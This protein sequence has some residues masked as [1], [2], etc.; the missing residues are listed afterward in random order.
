[1]PTLTLKLS[2]SAL[3]CVT[4]DDP[5][6]PYVV[7]SPGLFGEMRLHLLGF[8]RDAAPAVDLTPAEAMADPSAALGLLPVMAGD[9]AP[10]VTWNCDV[11]AAS[12]ADPVT[13]DPGVLPPRVLHIGV[14]RDRLVRLMDL[15]APAVQW[16]IDGD[17][18]NTWGEEPGEDRNDDDTL[19][20]S[21]RDA[22]SDADAVRLFARLHNTGMLTKIADGL[23][24]EA[25][26][27]L[28]DPHTH[29]EDTARID[30]TGTVT[31]REVRRRVCAD[32]GYRFM[33]LGACPNVKTSCL[34]CCGEDHGLSATASPALLGAADALSLAIFA[35]NTLL[36]PDASSSTDFEEFEARAADALDVLAALRSQVAEEADAPAPVAA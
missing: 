3:I 24:S 25:Y 11:I 13:H 35:V 16:D 6:G 9:E 28:S 33:D 21:T 14:H 10:M 23:L 4:S 22:L 15:T 32:C 8:Q 18:W 2:N 26:A 29:S 20:A 19:H 36:A 27:A 30:S 5:N 7:D 31:D 17:G 1:M 12:V 34:D